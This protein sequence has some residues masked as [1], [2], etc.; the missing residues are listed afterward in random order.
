MTENI[1][2][3]EEQSA[4]VQP[5]DLT[6][7]LQTCREKAGLDLEQAADE[8][9]LSPNLLRSLE[10][11]DFARLPEPPYVRGYL[12][13]Y[14]KLSGTD[15]KDLIRTYEALRGA[16]PDEIAH[17]FS[18]SRPL[19][20]V[21]PQPMFSPT[22][23]RFVSFGVLA[24][25][26]GGVT[27][28]PSVREWAGNTWAEFSAKTA[29]P[30]TPRPAPAL[31]TFNAQKDAEEKAAETTT[32]PAAATTTSAVN[33]DA[34]TAESKPADT[35]PD[36][37]PATASAAPDTAQTATVADKPAGT[38]TEVKPADTNTATAPAAASAQ[39]TPTNGTAEDKTAVTPTTTGTDTTPIAA[40]T[41]SEKPADTT[42]TTP[43]PITGEVSIKL[44][45]TE[46]SWM[47]IKDDNKKTLFEA[48]NSSGTT[49]EL[50]A[51][52]PL[53]FKIGNARG[54]K[55]Y[56]NGQLYDQAPHTK[57][58]VSRFKVE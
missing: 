51:T 14:A 48:L 10:K 49:K 43:T 15:P 2:P 8:M 42:T 53:N 19:G 25:I 39:D 22:T 46:E 44:E 5:G 34:T 4:T 18:P 58:S 36:I 31:E 41:D 28:M 38:G 1:T 50:K 12:R 47:Q 17:H 32:V 40:T 30:S 24:L 9:H 55:I 7:R 33:T 13:G 6:K 29:P 20:R 27:M 26:I 11:E 52:T 56:L 3:V 21:T 45:F 37:G 16:N 23:V 54:V 57:G 35:K